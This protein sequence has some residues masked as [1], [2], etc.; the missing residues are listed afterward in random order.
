MKTKNFLTIIAFILISCALAFGN[1]MP[2]PVPSQSAPPPVP[3]E[4][5]YYAVINGKQAG[6]FTSSQLRNMLSR[7]EIAPST[8][9]WTQGMANWTAISNVAELNN[10]NQNNFNNNYSNQSYYNS[11]GQNISNGELRPDESKYYFK[12]NMASFYSNQQAMQ[13]LFK[14]QLA[15]GIVMAA[16]SSCV[17]MPIGAVFLGTFSTLGISYSYS[18]YSGGYSYPNPY[19]F[20][21]VSLGSIFMVASQIVGPLCAIP[22]CNAG[23]VGNIYKKLNGRKLFQKLNQF[24]IGGGYDWENKAANVMVAIKL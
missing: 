17:L 2:P 21:A 15:G 8:Q 7:G 10:A 22:F 1:E 3:A 14:K 18:S 24:G 11:N 4:T 19:F 23:R 16:V 9:V 6:P 5:Q 13:D 12:K 20:V